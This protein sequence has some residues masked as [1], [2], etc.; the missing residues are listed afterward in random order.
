ML[1]NLFIQ[2]KNQGFTAQAYAH[3]LVVINHAVE[4][5]GATL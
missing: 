1:D 5:R 4:A 3:D 2:L